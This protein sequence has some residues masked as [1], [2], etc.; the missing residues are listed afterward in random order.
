M[1][2]KPEAL[3]ASNSW[4]SRT[5]FAFVASFF[6]VC[7]PLITGCSFAP[8][9]A[10]AAT[11]SSP[12]LSKQ[13]DTIAE[14]PSAKTAETNVDAAKPLGRRSANLKE[15]A[16]EEESLEPKSDK[17]SES[18]RAV[19]FRPTAATSALPKSVDDSQ[20]NPRK[21]VDKSK[22][23]DLTFDDLTFE[24]EKDEKFERSMLTP[25]INSY[26]GIRISLRGF[27][28]PSF[29]QS[30]LTKFVF[31][32]DNK[33]CCFGPGA[34]LY[35]CVLVRLAKGKKTDYTVRPVTVEGK[36]YLK[37]YTGPDGNVWSI[38]RM[39]DALVR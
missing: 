27:I 39:K 4:R 15:N 25:K 38:Y 9:D 8:E 37:E 16:A 35:D 24:M 22:T 36:F 20:Q 1:T 13:L 32:R 33:E 26:D 34:A 2:S 14:L 29:T 3:F 12:N 5:L 18:G 11:K 21:K 28:R 10:S 6:C 31:V 19:V 30:G 23:L 17:E 7:L